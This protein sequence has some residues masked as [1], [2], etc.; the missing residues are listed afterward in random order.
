MNR[1]ESSVACFM[2]MSRP[3]SIKW[4]PIRLQGTKNPRRFYE[5]SGIISWLS[6]SYVFF[7]S[8]LEEKLRKRSAENSARFGENS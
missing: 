6:G 4:T 1:S 5:L 8:K 7:D 2:G 3:R